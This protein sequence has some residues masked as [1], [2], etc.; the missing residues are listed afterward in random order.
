MRRW[1]R[2]TRSRRAQLKRADRD[3]W[4]AKYRLLLAATPE[5]TRAQRQQ[6]KH[7]HGYRRREERIRTLIAFNDLFV[8][9]VL[10][11]PPEALPRFSK[12]LYADMKLYCQKRREPYFSEEQFSAIVH[13]LSR[14]IAVYNGAKMQGFAARMTSRIEDGLGVDMQII[15]PASRRYINVD[16]KTPSAFR[17]RLIDLAREGRLSEQRL[18][19]GMQ[20]GYVAVTSGHG[21]EKFSVVVLKVDPDALGEVKDFAFEHTGELGRLLREIIAKH[22]LEDD[23]YGKPI[24]ISL[25]QESG[26]DTILS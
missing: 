20:T 6:D 1:W 19:A 18:D 2:R 16:C 4:K 13:G 15:D 23:G 5:A 14:E 22:G 7:R 11:V 21:D 17:Y 3:S 10:M 24:G 9:M 8:D 12:R 25:T 26:N